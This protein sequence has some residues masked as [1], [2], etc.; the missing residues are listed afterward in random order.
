[1]MRWPWNKTENDLD[2]EVRHHLET[3][4]DAFE[5]QGMSRPDAVRQA[6]I[7]FGGVERVKD[8]CR[9]ERSW[10]WLANIFE[11]A[12]FGWRMM[13]KT[14]TITLAAILSLALGI[15]ATTAILTLADGLLWRTVGAPAPRQLVELMWESKV[16]ADG[17]VQG[18]GVAALKTARSRS[19]ISSVK[20]VIRRCAASWPG[21]RK[22][23]RTSTAPS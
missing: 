16:P 21:R 13:R 20:P 2:R 9:D 8:E 19:G 17:L 6:R 15:G 12:R 18:P 23:R 3:L 5:R 4:A 11:D 7:E 22:S 1:M 14:P 10:N